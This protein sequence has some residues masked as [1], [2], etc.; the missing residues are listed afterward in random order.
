MV[1]L[2]RFKCISL[3]NST[4]HISWPSVQSYFIHPNWLL[5]H[6][7][8]HQVASSRETFLQDTSRGILT[9]SSETPENSFRLPV[10]IPT[11]GHLP[12]TSFQTPQN[13]YDDKNNNN[14]N[15]INL[16]TMTLESMWKND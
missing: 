15:N 14:T 6:P 16:S 4:F 8:L 11:V 3:N 7:N 2:I 1:A 9:I 10:Y 13:L 12:S 5:I